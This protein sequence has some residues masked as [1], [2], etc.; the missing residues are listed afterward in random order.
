MNPLLRRTEFLTLL[1]AAM[2]F[3]LCISPAFAKKRAPRFED[4][5]VH[6]NFVGKTA[7]LVWTPEARLFRT[8]IR[9]AAKQKPNFAGHFIVAWWGCGSGCVS[10]G[11][12]D[13]ETGETFVTHQETGYCPSADEPDAQ[14][15]PIIEYRRDSK[16][17]IFRGALNDNRDII[18][19]RFL[20][21]QNHRLKLIR[22]IPIHCTS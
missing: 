20:K 10:V 15:E 11:I 18:S 14:T 9:K 13:A 12:I 19:T 8:R 21:F 16:L 22:S 2:M 1:L 4:Y 5:H 17:L 6:E 7:P 3:S